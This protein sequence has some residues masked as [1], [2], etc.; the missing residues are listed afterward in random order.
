MQKVE[1]KK[2]DVNVFFLQHDYRLLDKIQSLIWDLQ[3]MYTY[4]EKFEEY[5][6]DIIEKLGVFREDIKKRMEHKIVGAASVIFEK[7]GSK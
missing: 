6:D 3:D 1:K 5:K 2:V 4:E 7:T